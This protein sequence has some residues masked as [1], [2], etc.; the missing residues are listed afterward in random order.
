MLVGLRAGQVEARVERVLGP[1]G[2]H[3]HGLFGHEAEHDRHGGEHVLGR[4]GVEGL[5]GSGGGRRHTHDPVAHERRVCEAD[6]Y[7]C[8]TGAG[9]S[10]VDGRWARERRDRGGSD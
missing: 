8:R 6:A 7:L 1:E 4:A 3:H 9:R 5:R 2:Q 10:G